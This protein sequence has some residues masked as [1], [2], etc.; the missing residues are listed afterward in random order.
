MMHQWYCMAQKTVKIVR[1]SNED[2]FVVGQVGPET[3]KGLGV[4]FPELGDEVVW[5]PQKAT[6]NMMS[7]WAAKWFAAHDSTAFET[8]A[9]VVVP[10]WMWEE[11]LLPKVAALQVAPAAEEKEEEG[12]PL[13]SEGVTIDEVEEWTAERA[14]EA[15]AAVRA[16]VASPEV[17]VQEQEDGR[18]CWVWESGEI[19]TTV[20][21]AL[22]GV[23]LV[24][25]VWAHEE[26][27]SISPEAA[28]EY[29]GAIRAI[30]AALA[31]APLPDQYLIEGYEVLEKTGR[32][33]A[34]TAHILVPRKYIGARVKVVICDPVPRDD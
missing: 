13:P 12:L 14:P 8:A 6:R 9:L 29:E 31:S 4:V 25:D 24:L 27:V 20:L 19:P 11:K 21:D 2:E 34:N 23:S 3:R 15:L 10:D 30:D 26:P 5:F 7:P 18:V 22:E 33:H 28:A 1:E 16:V 17:S 32:R